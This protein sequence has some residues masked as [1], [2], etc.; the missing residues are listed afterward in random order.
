VALLWDQNPAER[1]DLEELIGW[2]LF[3]GAPIAAL[4]IFV[5]WVARWGR[6]RS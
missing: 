5:T 4:V 6:G 3:I 2:V 1:S